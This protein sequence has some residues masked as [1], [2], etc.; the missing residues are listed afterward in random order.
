MK[1][2]PTNRCSAVDDYQVYL[3]YLLPHLSTLLGFYGANRWCRQRFGSYIAKQKAY[4]VVCNRITKGDPNTVVFYGN[5]GFSSSSRGHAPGPVKEMRRQLAKRCTVR[6]TSEFRTSA[7]CSRCH[8]PFTGRSP[9][10][11]W[12]LKLCK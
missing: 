12:G 7:F 3:R 6:L 2:I 5:A 8:Q 9:N 10:G 4:D 1:D 11:I